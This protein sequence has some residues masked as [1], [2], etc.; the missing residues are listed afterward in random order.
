[1]S[2]IRLEKL[3]ASI[4]ESVSLIL[5]KDVNDPRIGFVSITDVTITPD[6]QHAKIYVSCMGSEEE[7][8]K[9]MQGLSSA[10]PFIR[11]KLGDT[12][13][14]RFV[15]EIMFIQDTSL[16]RGS[17]ILALMN[18]LEREKKNEK[19]RTVG[20]RKKNKRSK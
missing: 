17:R 3:A 14:L 18:K 16:E 11:G 8:S 2:S 9:S 6:L 19:K 20:N 5:T 10:T 7:Q 1:M 12:L 13:F 4:K 15:P